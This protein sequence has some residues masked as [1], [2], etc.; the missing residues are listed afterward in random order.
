MIFFQT[1]CFFAA[2]GAAGTGLHALRKVT[3]A[4]WSPA[5]PSAFLHKDQELNEPP[6]TADKTRFFSYLRLSAFICG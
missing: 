4:R 1:Y 3:P 5:C 2:G 6:T